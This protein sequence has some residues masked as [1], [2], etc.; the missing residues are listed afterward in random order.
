[1]SGHGALTARLRELEGRDDPAE[2]EAWFQLGGEFDSTG[3][4]A[5]AMTAYERVFRYGPDNLPP[6]AR[7]QLYLQAASTLRNLDRIEESRA[8]F[9]QGRARFPEFGALTAFQA[10]LEITAGNE[11]AG[12]LLLLSCLSAADDQS[13]SLARYRRSLIGYTQA[14]ADQAD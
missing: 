12:N 8:L 10:L 1:M 5:E 14:L 3:Y 9:E 2:I 11:R 13:G 4:E 7:P 6:A